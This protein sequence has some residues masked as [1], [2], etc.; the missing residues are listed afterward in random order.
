MPFLN[1]KISGFSPP[2]VLIAGEIRSDL[3]YKAKAI[4]SG[5]FTLVDGSVSGQSVIG[6]GTLPSGESGYVLSEFPSGETPSNLNDSGYYEIKTYTVGMWD[7]DSL[8]EMMSSSFNEN[9][10]DEQY[11]IGAISLDGLY[12]P[13]TTASGGNSLLP[14]FEYTE[15]TSDGDIDSRTLNPFNPLNKIPSSGVES[16][17]AG[18]G[19]PS[20]IEGYWLKYGHNIALALSSDLLSDSGLHDF[21]FEEDYTYRG[22]VE[23]TGIRSVALRGPLVI[24]GWGFDTDGN[25]VPASGDNIHP[26]A[27]WNPN[28]WKVGPVDLRW[29]ND[30]NVWTGGNTTKIFLVKMTNIYNPPN[31]SYEVERSSSRSQFTRNAPSGMISYS[32]NS[33]IY[34]PEYVAYTAN[35]D[36]QGTYEQLDYAGIEFPYYEAFII[37]E[38]TDNVGSE[39]YNIGTEDCQDC[40]HITNPCE[41]GTFPRH[42][43]S[44]T[45]AAGKKILIEN[46]LK[47]SFDTGDLAFTVKTGRKKSVNTGNFTGGSGEN[48]SGVVV[49]DSSGNGIF[50]VLSAGSGYTYGGF[51]IINTNICTDLSL[52]FDGDVLVSGSISPS[53]NFPPNQSGIVDIYPADAIAE[54]E[55]LDIHWVTQ[56]EFK[57]QQVNTH[58]E[59]DGGILQTCSVKI[60][61]QGYKTCE[62]CGEDTAFINP[63]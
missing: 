31:F 60:Q 59:C 57:H 51:G 23:T 21:N 5:N 3:R 44:G 29:D 62:W 42:E 4:D 40:G 19:Y 2:H 14:H 63:F 24:G 26:E 7:L 49:I 15:E 33:A 52:S 35:S 45:L 9:N 18:S 28:L 41:S 34:D 61:T 56:A 50:N 27:F 55:T 48:A 8:S 20:G 53:S 54:T 1:N 46:P 25:P 38:T 6:I 16:G 58:V 36:N 12:I 22:K 17:H 13:Y 37:R 47:Q 43:S 32:Q 30:R 39:Y 10:S 11:N